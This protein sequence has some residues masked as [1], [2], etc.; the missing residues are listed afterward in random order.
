[1]SEAS[2]DSSRRTWTL[3]QSYPGAKFSQI[4]WPQG[5]F[6]GTSRIPST[7]RHT[8]S[9][10]AS[11]MGSRKSLCRDLTRSG[12]EFRSGLRYYT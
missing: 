8:R 7:S 9:G 4:W 3:L 5:F 12:D 11:V 6:A 2:S 1:M 10:L